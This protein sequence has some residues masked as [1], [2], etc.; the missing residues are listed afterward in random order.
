MNRYRVTVLVVCCILIALGGADINS[1]LRN[2]EPEVVAWDLKSGALEPS[3]EWLTLDGGVLMLEEAISTS[4]ELEIDALLVPYVR[5]TDEKKFY[6]LIETRDPQLVKAFTTYH[7]ALESE[8]EKAKYLAD[9]RGIFRMQRSVSGMVVQGLIANRNRDTLF[10]FASETGMDVPEE[11]VFIHEGNE[12][13]PIYRGLF[14]LLMA[15]AG[16]IKVIVVGRKN[17]SAGVTSV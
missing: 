8:S 6:V 9:N 17:K 3:K 14:F 11:V 1:I 2:Y 4:G 16:I 15:I 5:D 12:P 10:E 7:L 13:P